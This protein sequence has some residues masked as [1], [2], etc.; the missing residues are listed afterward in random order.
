MTLIKLRVFFIKQKGDRLNKF[1]AAIIIITGIFSMQG[2]QR[3]ELITNP[4][5]N[6]SVK[7]TYILSEGNG[8][9]NR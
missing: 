2:C 7:G 1:I 9:L 5:A 4:P 3:D 6:T 8:T